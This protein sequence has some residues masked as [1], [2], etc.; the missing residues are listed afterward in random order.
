M[1]TD[2]EAPKGDI[3]VVSSRV[4]WRIGNFSKLSKMHFSDTFSAHNGNLMEV[5][6]SVEALAE[7]VT[8]TQDIHP[9][10]APTQR[11]ELTGILEAVAEV[12]VSGAAN[13]DKFPGAGRLYEEGR[14]C[15]EVNMDEKF[16]EVGG[17]RVLKT[18]ASLYK[19]IWLNY[20]HIASS[21]FLR[22]Y[23]LPR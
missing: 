2:T 4:K 10:G 17:F 9:V 7:V 23:I 12:K 16:E 15:K 3:A 6:L 11:S 14:Y 5:E 20:G 13:K 19:E 1:S 21:Q 18:Q 8:P 22:I